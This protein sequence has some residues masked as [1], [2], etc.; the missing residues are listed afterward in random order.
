MRPMRPNHR[1]TI[2]PSIDSLVEQIGK[3]DKTSDPVAVD[4]LRES[5]VQKLR[6]YKCEEYLKRYTSETD[7]SQARARWEVVSEF[8]NRP[9][10]RDVSA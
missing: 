2:H 1:F 6:S 7:K 8:A 5:C 9:R 10:K 3:L 4:A